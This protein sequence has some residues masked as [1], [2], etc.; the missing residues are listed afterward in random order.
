MW[1][2][3]TRIILYVKAYKPVRITNNKGNDGIFYSTD[4]EPIYM[5]ICY[6]NQG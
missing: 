1:S 5:E 2:S 6:R 4:P 3:K